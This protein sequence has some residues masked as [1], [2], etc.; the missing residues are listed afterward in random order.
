MDTHSFS[1]VLVLNRQPTPDELDA[2]HQAG[3]SDAAFTTAT[4]G[5]AIAEFDRQALTLSDAITSAV[6]DVERGGLLPM[7]VVDQDLVTLGDI[8][9]RVGLSR[10]CVSRYATGHRGPGGF[11]PPMNYGRPG[12]MLYRWCE[13]V[14]WMR[15]MGVDMP[16]QDPTL[17]MANLVLQLRRIMLA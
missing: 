10:Q 6:A 8:A 4:G 13:V 5:V 12:I 15:D 3:C 1:F 7:R 2:L 16:Y 9:A 14:P 11:P 17:A